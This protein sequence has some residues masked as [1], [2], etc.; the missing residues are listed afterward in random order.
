[1]T[2]S[3]LLRNANHFR[4]RL[5]LILYWTVVAVL[6]WMTIPLGVRGLTSGPDSTSALLIA[7]GAVAVVL[8]LLPVVRNRIVEGELPKANAVVLATFLVLVGILQV[9]KILLLSDAAPLGLAFELVDKV[10]LLSLLGFAT[11]QLLLGVA[12]AG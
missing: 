7:M 8:A 10:V 9:P 12:K 6:I 2:S 5:N 1:M 4:T 11:V 3:R